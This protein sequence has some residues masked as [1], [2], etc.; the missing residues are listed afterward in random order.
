M[1]KSMRK[2]DSKTQILAGNPVNSWFSAGSQRSLT[3]VNS[4]D[5]VMFW[6]EN[7]YHCK[8]RQAQKFTSLKADLYHDIN[9]SNYESED[10]EQYWL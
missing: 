2:K 8:L 7:D 10:E 6:L 1:A 4:T 5:H 9:G 3:L